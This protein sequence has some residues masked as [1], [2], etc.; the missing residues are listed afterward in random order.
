MLH[1]GDPVNIDDQWWLERFRAATSRRIGMFGGDTTGFRWINGESDGLPALVVDRYADV[2]VVKVYASIWLP[3]V[4]EVLD[5]IR[6]SCDPAPPSVVLRLSRNIAALAEREFGLHDGDVLCGEVEASVIFQE[7]GK[8]F[9]AGVLKGQKTG[10]FLDQRENRKRVGELSRGK[11]VLNIFSHSG[12][13]SVY[14]AVGGARS[15]T[16]V[17]I[18]AHALEEARRNM[19]LNAVGACRHDT[20]KADAFAW[21]AAHHGRYDLVIID[22]PSLARRQSE[23]AGALV[24][25]G[26]LVRDGA[27]LVRP[28]GILL[29]ASCSAHVSAEEFLGMVRRAV[30]G[31][32]LET[33]LHAADHEAR[34][35]EAHYLKATYLRI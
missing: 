3:R 25:Y 29:A 2:C 33:R 30:R 12:G 10:F 21:L 9:E 14:A 27:K 31:E 28:G 19:A 15:T 17:D 13:F 24:A 35:P 8:R 23:K 26:R 20:V 4:N 7:N 16:D 6:A 11:D 5:W 34:I 18:S 22:P 1:V 32:E